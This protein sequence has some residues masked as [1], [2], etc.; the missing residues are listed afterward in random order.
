MLHLDGMKPREKS[1]WREKDE[2]LGRRMVTPSA[3][4]MLGIGGSGIYM[5]KG[6]PRHCQG[7]LG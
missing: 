3:A 2:K 4:L 5:E 6:I 1:G 7:R